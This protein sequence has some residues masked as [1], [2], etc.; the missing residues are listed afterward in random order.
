VGA[1]LATAFSLGSAILMGA[2]LQVAAATML[3]LF[4]LAAKHEPLHIRDLPEEGEG[5]SPGPI[6]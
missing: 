6:T 1:A 5:P 2:A 3:I 4:F